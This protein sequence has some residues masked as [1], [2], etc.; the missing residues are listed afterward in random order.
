VINTRPL[1]QTNGCTNLAA[2]TSCYRDGRPEV[3]LCE[4][5]VMGL[6]V[7]LDTPPDPHQTKVIRDAVPP[8]R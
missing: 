3:F 8:S 2:H 5:H 4:D 1:C 6:T 7:P